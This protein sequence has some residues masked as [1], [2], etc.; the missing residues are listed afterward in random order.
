MLVLKKDTHLLKKG[1]KL[2][3]NEKLLQQYN[4]GIP[5]NSE[6]IER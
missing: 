4:N 6:L 5:K 3:T 2:L 1:N